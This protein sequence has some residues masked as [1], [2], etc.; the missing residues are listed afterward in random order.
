MKSVDL[1]QNCVTPAARNE[2]DRRKRKT[3]ALLGKTLIQLL[4]QKDLKDITVRELTE[5]ADV[6]RGTFYLHYADIYDLFDQF[7]RE[8]L[9]EFSEVISKHKLHKDA[10]AYPVMVDTFKFIG[11]NA[12]LFIAI[13]RTKET[14]F[15]SKIVEMNKP[16]NREEWK[17]LVGDTPEEYHEY[18]YAFITSG[19]YAMLNRWFSQGMRDT[20]E[21]MAKLA[22]TMIKNCVNGVE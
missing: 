6:N 15:F 21:Y 13:L 8:L 19:L 1:G 17:K 22:V 12:D 7:E 3:K 18:Y 20:P 10:F 11:A 9:E 4:M 2:T 16:Q 5:L 14:S